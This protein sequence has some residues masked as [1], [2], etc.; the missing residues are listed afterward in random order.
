[1]SLAATLVCSLLAWCN[2]NFSGGSMKQK[3]QKSFVWVCLMLL[4]ALF[5]GCGG[6][7]SSDSSTTSTDAS[8][9]TVSGTAATGAPLIGTVT[10]KDA[11]GTQRGPVVLEH[12]GSFSFDVAG[13]TP[14]FIIRAEGTAGTGNFH[15]IAT[16]VGVANVNPISEAVAMAATPGKDLGA[17][18]AEGAT[19]TDVLGSTF[20]TDIA[21]DLAE[22]VA[23]LQA[24]IGP[25]LD[26]FDTDLDNFL[27]SPFVLNGP[28]D[29]LLDTVGISTD[30][31]TGIAIVDNSSGTSVT[32]AEVS[33]ADLAAQTPVAAIGDAAENIAVVADDMSEMASFLADFIVKLKSEI[34]V[35][36]TAYGQADGNA[37]AEIAADEAFVAAMSPYIVDEETFGL[38]NGDPLQPFILEFLEDFEEVAQLEGF[39]GMAIQEIGQGNETAAD[40]LL[41]GKMLWPGIVEP[42]ATPIGLVKVGDAW[43]LT[44]NG[45]RFDVEL[46]AETIRVVWN[47][48]VAEEISGIDIEVEVLYCDEIDQVVITGAGLPDGEVTLVP[49]SFDLGEFTFDE[50]DG[51]V[52]YRFLNDQSTH[53]IVVPEGL[54]ADLAGETYTVKAYDDGIL[55]QTVVVPLTEKLVNLA[56]MTDAE[57]DALFPSVTLGV[58]NQSLVGAVSLFDKD[59]EFAIT[60]SSIEDTYDHWL[61]A[62]W[63]YDG[64][65][66][67]IEGDND[68]IGAFVTATLRLGPLPAAG[69]RGFALELGSWGPTYGDIKTEYRFDV[70]SDPS[71]PD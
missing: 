70:S 69:V 40:Y 10:L 23:D 62:W 27:N 41:M 14:P 45:Y 50:S 57:K 1:M 18:F 24:L 25:L 65:W 53:D 36:A 5:A 51:E 30:V 58:V 28:A 39:V 46:T 63:W 16:D 26:A 66:D 2:V 12:D 19:P 22:A 8:S 38:D 34:V 32:L 4:G 35:W 33:F 7:G 54:F 61:D 37:D 17:V 55:L 42:M 6:G 31:E 67:E 71:L 21:A 60:M 3:I 56:A 44:G 13:L 48:G 11:E 47:D 9:A 43:K 20:K 29:L 49:H 64:G 15:S 59:T 68:I 52:A